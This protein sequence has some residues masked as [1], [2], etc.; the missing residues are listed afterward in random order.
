MK[1]LLVLIAASLVV[2]LISH[3]VK[4]YSKDDYHRYVADNVFDASSISAVM[5][6]FWLVYCVIC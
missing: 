2:M 4:K 1:I 5:F 6:V 3:L